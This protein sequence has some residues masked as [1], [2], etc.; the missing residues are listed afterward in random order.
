MKL[1]LKMI[2]IGVFFACL[3]LAALVSAFA[4]LEPVVNAVQRRFDTGRR[5]AA[6]LAAAGP[7]CVGVVAA[8]SFSI[9]S[10]LGAAGSD[11]RLKACRGGPK[12]SRCGR[13]VPASQGVF[14]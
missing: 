14:P 11:G 4:L 1:W 3:T 6:L 13:K 10:D 9:R 7:W 2:G 5:T 12:C 8:L